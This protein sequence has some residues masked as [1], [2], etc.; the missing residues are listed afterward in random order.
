MKTYYAVH[1]LGGTTPK[2]HALCHLLAFLRTV[3]AF[4]F[5]CTEY[6]SEP[7]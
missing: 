3:P 4:A 5:G 1:R 6:R 7:A 2:F